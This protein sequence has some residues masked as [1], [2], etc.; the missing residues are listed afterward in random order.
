[1]LRVSL[2]YGT[3]EKLFAKDELNG[4]A[5]WGTG[6]KGDVAEGYTGLSRLGKKGIDAT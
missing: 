1:M 6:G 5:C 2:W 3:C 4:S